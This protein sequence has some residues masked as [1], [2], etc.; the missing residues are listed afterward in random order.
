[1]LWLTVIVGTYI[2]F[3]AYRVTP[4]AGTADLSHF[5]RAF[6]LANAD[7]LRRVTRFASELTLLAAQLRLLRQAALGVGAAA[8]AAPIA[9]TPK[10]G[11]LHFYENTR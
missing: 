6:L 10:V 7:I 8:S 11:K 2:I 9:C 1:M 3:P 4:P 5:P